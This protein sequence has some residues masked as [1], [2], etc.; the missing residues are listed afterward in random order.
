[1]AFLKTHPVSCNADARTET[2]NTA[3]LA[4]LTAIRRSCDLLEAAVR[5][6][7]PG[8][9]PGRG[10]PPRFSSQDLNNNIVTPQK[11]GRP[12]S[13]PATP[14]NALPRRR[15]PRNQQ[16]R[17]TRNSRAFGRMVGR[18][19]S[20]EEDE[21]A[22][23][24]SESWIANTC[25][26]EDS[27]DGVDVVEIDDSSDKDDGRETSKENVS[28][29]GQPAKV[30]RGKRVLGDEDDDDDGH[31]ATPKK[32]RH[33]DGG[34]DNDDGDDDDEPPGSP[35]GPRP[36]SSADDLEDDHEE[37]EVMIDETDE[38]PED[39]ETDNDG[40]EEIAQIASR[41][42]YEVKQAKRDHTKVCDVCLWKKPKVGDYF[43]L[44]VDRA[45]CLASYCRERDTEQDGECDILVKFCFECFK[46]EISERG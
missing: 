10:T 34:D 3:V 17:S 45:R 14:Q 37:V 19:D 28:S 7:N 35:P 5:G 43:V 20:D 29:R 6:A 9:T 39:E 33:Y 40:L 44:C 31:R 27:G 11:E 4:A 16:P 15:S 8:A 13:N 24:S 32:R 46:K 41:E 36:A 18:I 42:G 22:N 12:A 2:F 26:E 23:S 1:M 30:W 25:S 21:P 38:E